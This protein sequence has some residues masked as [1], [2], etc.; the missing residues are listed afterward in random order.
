[1]TATKISSAHAQV[2]DS[3]AVT[4]LLDE[5]PEAEEIREQ[6]CKPCFARRWQQSAQRSFWITSDGH[7]AVCLT[8]TGLDVDEVVAVWVAF[9]AYRIRPGF[10]LSA[11]SLGEIIQA[12]LG[13]LV[14]F[15]N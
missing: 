12:E 9:D 7:T 8:L 13:V 10:S 3:R 1:M 11:T 15:E 6:L 2:A 14:E 4:R 5:V